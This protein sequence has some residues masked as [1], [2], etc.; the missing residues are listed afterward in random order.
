M[1]VQQRPPRVAGVDGSIRL[2]SF[3]YERAFGAADR[4][5]RAD[6]AARHRPRESKGITDR[7]NFLAHL[8]VLGFAQHGGNDFGGLDLD[9]RQIVRA[10]ASNHR[11]L[12]GLLVM[13][14]H[15]QLRGLAHYVIVGEDM[16]R[17][18]D[19]EART[20][21]LFG[22]RSIKEVVCHHFGSDIDDRWD[23]AMVDIDVVLLFG[24]EFLRP[25]GFTEFDVR[26]T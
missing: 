11:R 22:H 5:E 13:Q 17:F 16:S 23:H 4:T 6:D 21:A 10:V 9:H 1:R 7:K 3:I 14:R 19:D 25:S 12:V 2:D 8:Q 20:L 15:F 26:G 18:V 24:I